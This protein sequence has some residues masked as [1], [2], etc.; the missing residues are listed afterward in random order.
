MLFL[1]LTQEDFLTIISS[2]KVQ[3]GTQ[4]SRSVCLFFLSGRYKIYITIQHN[5]NLIT[6]YWSEQKKQKGKT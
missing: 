5:M 4:T 1:F 3:R 6:Q 2:A